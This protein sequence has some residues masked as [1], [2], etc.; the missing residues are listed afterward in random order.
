MRFLLPDRD[1]KVPASFDAVFVSEGIEV[2]M[3]CLPGP[4]CQCRGL[5][6]TCAACGRNV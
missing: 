4:E 1:M 5:A 3:T 2:S 6:L